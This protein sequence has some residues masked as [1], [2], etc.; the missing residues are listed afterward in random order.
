MPCE[1]TATD[2]KNANA[3]TPVTSLLVQVR[4]PSRDRATVIAPE[5]TELSRSIAT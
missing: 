2:G 5:L 3:L 1:S 4:P